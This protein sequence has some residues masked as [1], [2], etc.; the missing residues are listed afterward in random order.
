VSDITENGQDICRLHLCLKEG[1][2]VKAD[3][4]KR[5]RQTGR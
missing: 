4:T 3:R 2:C 5:H 1:Q